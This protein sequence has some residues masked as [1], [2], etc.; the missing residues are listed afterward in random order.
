MTPAKFAKLIDQ[1][2]AAEAD[3]RRAF[4]RWDKLQERVRRASKALDK[5]FAK[6]ADGPGSADWREFSEEYQAGKRP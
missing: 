1:L 4:R 6:R 2:H 3:M 5:Q